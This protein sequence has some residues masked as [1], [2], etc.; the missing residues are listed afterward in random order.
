GC[1]NI[2]EDVNNPNRSL[3]LIESEPSTGASVS[4]NLTEIILIF[5]NDINKVSQLALTDLITDSDIQG[6]D[7]NIEGNKVIINN[8]SLEPTCNYRLS[9]EVIDIYDNHLQ[10]Y[11]E[12]LVNQSNYPQ[13]PDQEV[14]HTILQAFY[15]EMNTGE[16]A[17][18]HP[19]EANLWNLLAERAPELAEAGFTA[20]WLPPANKGMAGIHDVGYGTYDL[21]DLGEFDQKGTVRTKYGTKGELEN[22]IDALHNNDIKVYF[23][24]VLNHR[25]GADYAET[26]LLD[27]NSRDKPGQYIKAWTGFNFPGRNGEY[28]NFTWNGQC[29]DG[30]DWDDY[31]KESGKYLFDEKSWDWTYN[32]DEDYLMGADVDYENEAVQNDVIDW[33]Q[34]II[35]NIDFDGFRLDAVKHI[36]YRFIDKWMS[37]VQNSSNRDVFFVG[38]AWVEDVDDLKGFLDTVG[39]PDL[40]VF[41]FPLRSFFVDMLNGAYMADLRNAGLVNSPGYENRAVTFVDNHD[42]DRDEGSYTVSIYSRKYQA[43]AYILTRAEGVPTVYWKDYYIWEMKEGLDKLLTARRY[44]AY[45]PGYEVDNNDADIYSYVRSGFPD[46]AGDGL[47]LMISDGT[48]GNVAGKWIN[49]RQPDTEFYD[50][51]GHIK[52]HVTTDSEGYGNFKVIKSEDKGWSI[53]VPVE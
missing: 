52:E 40:R 22:A 26:V 46:V 28:S 5:S 41:D 53:W 3:F 34:W 23:D 21:W 10:G 48:S 11:I 44:Y 36:D 15:W 19:E 27:E 30:T 37:A 18:E 33:G 35:N 12:F 2:S 42:T 43:Y 38:E 47:V 13:I 1:S 32:W 29:F 16:Y 45:G 6:I 9:Y 39:N 20:V 8:F 31:S 17:T 50:L 14:N 25:M 51:T 7:Y 49:S 4:K 24:A